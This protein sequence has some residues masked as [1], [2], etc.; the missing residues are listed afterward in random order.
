M[1]QKKVQFGQGL[2]KFDFSNL[3]PKLWD[4]LGL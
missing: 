2:K 3:V 1:V 4:T